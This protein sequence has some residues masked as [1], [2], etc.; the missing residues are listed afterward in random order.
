MRHIMTTAALPISIL[1]VTRA[2]RSTAQPALGFNAPLRP[3][4]AP[5]APAQPSSERSTRPTP[6]FQLFGH[7]KPQPSERAEPAAA[8]RQLARFPHSS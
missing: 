1:L 5:S 3:R 4:H 6:A 2:R 8:P 7:Q